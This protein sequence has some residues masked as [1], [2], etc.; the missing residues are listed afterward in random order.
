VLAAP[1]DSSSHHRVNNFKCYS[2]FPSNE[3]RLKV[4]IN[5]IMEFPPTTQK[6]KMN[7]QATE[8]IKYYVW[9]LFLRNYVSQPLP[10]M[11]TSNYYWLVSC[12]KTELI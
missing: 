2:G 11:V 5:N 12:K 10:N 8:I 4:Y 1:S 7:I 6:D 9:Y 3:T